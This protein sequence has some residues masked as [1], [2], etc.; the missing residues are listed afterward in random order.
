MLNLALDDDD[1]ELRNATGRL[2]MTAAQNVMVLTARVGDHQGY[3]GRAKAEDDRR[4]SRL[5][6]KGK[7]RWRPQGHL[8]NR[9]GGC[10]YPAD[11]EAENGR[12]RC[13][14]Q[15]LIPKP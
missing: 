12:W 15:E 10:K 3:P 13:R 1:K 6:R 14:Y 7:W 2:I 4:I 8:P 9:A 5:P 11:I